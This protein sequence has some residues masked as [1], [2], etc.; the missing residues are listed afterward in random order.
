MGVNRFYKVIGFSGLPGSG[1]ST[2]IEAIKDIGTVVTM[3]DVVRYEAKKQG[4]EPTG[5]NLG[6]IA[7]KLRELY[8]PSIIARKCVELIDTLND[9]IIFIDGVRSIYEV[10]VFRNRWKFPLVVI[11][12]NKKERLNRIASRGRSDDSINAKEFNKRDQRELAFGIQDVID[13]ADYKIVNDSNIEVLKEKTKKIVL[14]IIEN[15]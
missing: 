14:E 12:M 15:Y 6:K 7:K 13:I 11:Q 5:E 10:E 3:G 8:G 2:A 1:K 9:S 4:I